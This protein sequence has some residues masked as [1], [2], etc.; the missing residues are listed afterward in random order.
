MQ[1]PRVAEATALLTSLTSDSSQNRVSV[2]FVQ[3][4]VRSDEPH[5]PSHEAGERGVDKARG[6]QGMEYFAQNDDALSL[7][8]RSSR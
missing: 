2:V 1:V 6:L 7:F 3:D 8:P 5:T 4:D